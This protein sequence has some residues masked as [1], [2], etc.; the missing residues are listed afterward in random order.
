M[1]ECDCFDGLKDQPVTIGAIHCAKCGMLWLR[2]LGP[3]TTINND[4]KELERDKEKKK[5]G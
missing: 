5:N 4:D 2:Q 1:D 3:W